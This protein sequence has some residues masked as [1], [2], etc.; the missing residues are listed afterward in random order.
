[1]EAEGCFF[2]KISAFAPLSAYKGARKQGGGNKVN[3]QV[4]V[5]FQITQH[6]RDALLIKSLITLF[7]C[8]RVEP[9]SRGPAVN[10][11]FVV[12]KFSDITEKILPFFYQYP[13][14]G[15]KAQDFTDFCK[16]VSLMKSKAHLTKG[17][18]EEIRKI[19][20]VQRPQ[21]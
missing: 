20:S 17:G 15:S 5:G 16:V 19:K 11:N 14:I 4:I 10:L 9:Y 3:Y 7:D 1:M 13:L 8:G 21:V 6:S 18:L 2:V 12:S